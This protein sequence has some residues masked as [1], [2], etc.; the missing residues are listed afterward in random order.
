MP[1]R[2]RYG[3]VTWENLPLW[4]HLRGRGEPFVA[5]RSAPYERTQGDARVQGF[6]VPVAQLLGRP[7]EYRDHQVSGPLDGVGTALA[8]PAGQVGASLRLESVVEGI[9]VT[10][11]IRLEARIE[12]S[13][14]LEVTTGPIDASVTEL[15][16]GP[17]HLEASDEDTYRIEGP[18]LDLEPMIR[19][20]VGLTLPLHPLCREGCRGLCVQCGKNL[21]T[22]PCNCTEDDLDPRWDA[23][24]D[25]R[26]KLATD[27]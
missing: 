15:Y 10:G 12:C 3:A 27:S 13:R 14:C 20:A 18:E 16:V 2:S 25:L 7:G 5:A 22:G 1:S 19:D 6:T 26:E 4:Y 17:G 11:T 8:R 21:N 23:L 24:A 9:L